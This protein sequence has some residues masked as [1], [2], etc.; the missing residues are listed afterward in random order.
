VADHAE[1]P[2][3]IDSLAILDDGRALVGC[4]DGS[5]Y[6]V[7][8]TRPARIEPTFPLGQAFAVDPEA[9][10]VAIADRQ[11][12]TLIVDLAANAAWRVA[13]A[14]PPQSTPALSGDAASVILREPS[15]LR[16][17]GAVLVWPLD[18]PTSPEATARWVERLTNADYDPRLAK[19][20]WR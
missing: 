4:I 11:P 14:L 5:A 20:T 3:Q 19:L 16:E 1:L 8:L 6:L 10:L 13:R 18:L 17:P 7:S 12:G 2:A 15:T 9:G